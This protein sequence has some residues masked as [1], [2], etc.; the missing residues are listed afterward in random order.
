MHPLFAAAGAD[1][2][3]ADDT[4]ADASTALEEIKVTFV[5]LAPRSRMKL[6]CFA[7]PL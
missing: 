5:V 2:D 6:Q 4:A 7:D 1:G 3:S